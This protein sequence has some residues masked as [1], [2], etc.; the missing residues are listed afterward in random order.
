MLRLA[1]ETLISFLYNVLRLLSLLFFL[2]H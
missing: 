2:R 1:I